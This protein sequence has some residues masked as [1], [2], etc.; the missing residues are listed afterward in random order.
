MAEET[1]IQKKEK[2]VGCRLRA[3]AAWVLAAVLVYVLSLGP[4]LKIEYSNGGPS[5]PVVDAF[6]A[7]LDWI[8]SHNQS[9]DVLMRWYLGGVWGVYP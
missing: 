6:Y 7:P 9:A 5:S 2:G 1:V 4:V 3:W 8:C